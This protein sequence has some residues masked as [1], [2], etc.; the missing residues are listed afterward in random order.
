M[1]DTSLGSMELR[2]NPRVTHAGNETIHQSSSSILFGD[3]DDKARPWNVSAA[4]QFS[5]TSLLVDY[6]SSTLATFLLLDTNNTADNGQA[7]GSDLVG[8]HHSTELPTKVWEPCDAQNPMFNCS[9]LDFLEY[10]QGP[11]TMPYP[12][13]IMVSAIGW[14]SY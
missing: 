12:K 14:E 5:T 7:N 8:V 13:A 6:L 10:Y 3:N 11:Q 1:E 4:A 9:V 2:L